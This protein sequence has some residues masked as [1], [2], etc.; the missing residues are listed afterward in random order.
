MQQLVRLVGLSL[1]FLRLSYF[2]IGVAFTRNGNRY[3][4]G[5]ER[6]RERG[7]VKV[8]AIYEEKVVVDDV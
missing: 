2:V 6:E 4:M 7:N 1:F 3:T 8:L 5:S